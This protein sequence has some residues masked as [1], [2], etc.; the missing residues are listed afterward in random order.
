MVL[1]DAG[2]NLVE[3]IRAKFPIVSGTS[4]LGAPL[5]MDFS[6]TDAP[7]ASHNETYVHS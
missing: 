3:V 1:L 6:M 4:I 2:L 7:P 5:A